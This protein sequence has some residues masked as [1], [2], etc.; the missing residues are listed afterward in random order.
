MRFRKQKK[1]Y[2]FLIVIKFLKIT[3][4]LVS[5]TECCPLLHLEQF[6]SNKSNLEEFEDIIHLPQW[7]PSA[8]QCHSPIILE[9][10][11]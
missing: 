4:A 5:N 2:F 6:Y 11:Y 3:L 7:S 9:E 10:H 1:L 8:N